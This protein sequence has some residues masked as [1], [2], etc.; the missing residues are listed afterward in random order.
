MRS[1]WEQIAQYY[2]PTLNIT[3]EELLCAFDVV[4]NALGMAWITEQENKKE[5]PERTLSD[6][7]PLYRELISQASTSLVHVHELKQYLLAFLSDP[8]LPAVIQDL[9]DEGKYES[10][11][12]E[13]AMAFRWQAAGAVVTLQP[14]TPKGKA[15]FDAKVHDA[16]YIVEA[17]MLPAD[18]IRD[19]RVRGANIAA[20]II[21]KYVKLRVPVTARVVLRPAPGAISAVGLLQNSLKEACRRFEACGDDNISY[22]AEF[23]SIAL[24]TVKGILDP[25]EPGWDVIMSKS[26]VDAHGRS[27]SQYHTVLGDDTE[28]VEHIRLFMRYPPKPGSPV[29]R[30]VRKLH[31]E[32]GQLSRVA[33]K[34]VILD[35]SALGKTILM[36]MPEQ[37]QAAVMAEMRSSRNLV[38]VWIV[39]RGYSEGERFGYYGYYVANPESIN[40][41]PRSFIERLQ[42]IERKLALLPSPSRNADAVK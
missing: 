13:L 17:S 20:R 5:R 1:Q 21:S 35:V 18:P 9:R 39:Q 6:E 16:H 23:F 26:F 32:R 24:E 28:K 7:H 4:C 22:E 12:L 19:V 27:P 40:Q 37:I 34:L 31:K 2:S 41:I 38:G 8:A 42:E 10:A 33:Q 30:I 29:D 14:P 25:S 15:D 36:G 11:L 3:V